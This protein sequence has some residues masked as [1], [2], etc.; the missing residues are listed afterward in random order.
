[1]PLR[2]LEEVSYTKWG[3]CGR[4]SVEFLRQIDKKGLKK[5]LLAR[6]ESVKKFLVVSECVCVCVW[7]HCTLGII[8]HLTVKHRHNVL[9]R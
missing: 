5:S 3:E 9:C 4:S 6:R 8:L 2:S 7:M 1:M